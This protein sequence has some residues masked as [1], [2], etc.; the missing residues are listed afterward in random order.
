MAELDV[1]KNTETIA[2][3]V[4]SMGAGKS[5][6]VLRLLENEYWH[7]YE[8][9]VILCPTITI[10]STYIECN[11]VWEDPNIYTI[12]PGDELIKCIDWISREARG[13][14]TLFIV[15]DCIGK[16]DLNKTRGPLFELAISVRHRKHS[17]WFLTQTY[18]GIP[19][20][21]RRLANMLFFWFLKGKND[22]K[23]VANENAFI[24]NWS[25]IFKKL[26]DSYSKH[27]FAYIRGEKPF[28]LQIKEEDG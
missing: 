15:D 11:F 12:K 26:Q 13:K 8:I 4:G 23:K 17:L 6:E 24:D 5:R 3:F 9:I 7:H 19:Y 22:Q 21:F 18:V 10:N 25:H 20:K 27:S 2:L 14:K 1:V 16:D 28:A